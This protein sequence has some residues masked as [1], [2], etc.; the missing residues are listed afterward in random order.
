VRIGLA[1]ET[2]DPGGA[3]TMLLHLARELL[4]RGHEVVALGPEGGSGWLTGR[5]RDLGVHRTLIPVHGYRGAASV[6]LNLSRQIRDQRLDVLHSHEFAMSVYGAPASQLAGCRHVITMH[7]STYFAEH[8]R[9]LIGLRLAS[10]LSDHTVAVSG[11]LRTTLAEHLRVSPGTIRLVRNGVNVVPASRIPVRAELG[12]DSDDILV[13]AVGSLYPVKGH[14]VLIDAVAEMPTNMRPLVAIAGSGFEEDKLR[15]RIQERGVNDRVLLLGYRPD[16]P[17]LLAAAD[18]YVMPSL[19]EGLP[20]AMIEAMLAS[21]PIVAS[22]AGG[23]GELIPSDEFGVLVPPGDPS[24]LKEALLRVAAAPEL[25]ERL[26]EAGRRRAEGE[27]TADS[28][29]EQYLRLYET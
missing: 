4:R 9:R 14:A 16:V 13:V 21:R 26:G 22:D 12:A 3:E 8:P 29:A 18:I 28:M 24:A 10:A 25:R 27:F 7:G 5:L 1:I 23:I 2:D 6:V 11:A 17:D 15:A 20:M 19:S